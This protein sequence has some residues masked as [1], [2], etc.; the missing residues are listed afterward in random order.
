MM[1]LPRWLVSSVLAFQF[2]LSLLQLLDAYRVWYFPMIRGS[3]YSL[4]FDLGFSLVLALLPVSALVLIYLLKNGRY[5]EV[6]VAV[7]V[8]VGFY[9][10]FGVEAAV[11]WF[12]VFQV[13]LALWRLVGIGEF[14][15]WLLFFLTGFEVTALVHWA[16]LPFGVVTP[17]AW[18]ADL[19]LALFYVLAPMAPLVVLAI[20]LIVILKLL[21]PQYLIIARRFFRVPFSSESESDEE[22]IRLHPKMFLVASVA[23]SVVAALYPYS[24][25]INPDG[26]AFG[27]DVHY[28]LDWM[29]PVTQD[30]SSAFTVANGSRPVLLLLIY[31]VQQGLG[32]KLLDAIKYLPVLLNPLLVIS[33]YFMVSQA[34]GDQ[35]W[36]GLTSLI[37]AS[38]FKI[39]VGMYAYFLTNILGLIF[40]FSALGFLFK[41]LRTRQ[42][43]YFA[44]ASGLG[45]LAVFTHPWTFAQYY[46]ATALFLF[47][48]YFREKRSSESL[49]VLTYLVITGLVD[50]LKGVIGGL[51]AYGVIT[52]IVPGLV[53]VGEFWGNNIFAFRQMYGG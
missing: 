29:G 4:R 11:A 32:L 6:I 42:K 49:I 52:S 16:L 28:Y 18:F 31:G 43:I 5:R 14:F 36:A 10:L 22:E 8:S 23:L 53:W 40:I 35:E 12:S 38:G 17:L 13:A 27:V 33:V 37:T 1:R 24:G 48:I 46:A 25:N 47:Y 20:I 50:V 44:S 34:T 19:E 39:T 15:F 51:G 41:T 2:L 45:S 26:I 30:L 3:A 21:L 9:L 7:T